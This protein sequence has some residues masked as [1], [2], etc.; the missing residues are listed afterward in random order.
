MIGGILVLQGIRTGRGVRG[1]V[2]SLRI[3][4]PKDPKLE[5]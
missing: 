1:H 4:I 5:K 3:M 2:Y